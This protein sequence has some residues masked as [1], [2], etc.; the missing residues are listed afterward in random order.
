MVITATVYCQNVYVV[1]KT[2]DPDPFTYKFDNID[3]LW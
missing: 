1:T 3:S 2:T